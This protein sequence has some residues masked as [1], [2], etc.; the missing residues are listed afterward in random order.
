M[1]DWFI[2]IFRIIKN[3]TNS[4]QYDRPSVPNVEELITRNRK[5]IRQKDSIFKLGRFFEYVLRPLSVASNTHTRVYLCIKDFQ[6]LYSVM[7]KKEEWSVRCNYLS[8]PL[9]REWFSFS[10]YLSPRFFLLYSRWFIESDDRTRLRRASVYLA[11]LN[12]VYVLVVAIARF[13]RLST[14]WNCRTYVP[15]RLYIVYCASAITLPFE[16]LYLNIYWGKSIFDMF[17]V[18]TIRSE[19]FIFEVLQGKLSGGKTTRYFRHYLFPQSKIRFRFICTFQLSFLWVFTNFPVALPKF[20]NFAVLFFP[21][22]A[23]FLQFYFCLRL[24]L[25]EWDVN[26]LERHTRFVFFFMRKYLQSGG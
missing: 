5:R 14:N 19:N 26:R 20:E 18:Y 24:F 10:L 3:R 1:R 6:L 21:C 4:I 22:T 7:I 13:E 16:Y 23:P 17:P 8:P 15:I 9:L 25:I 2:G 11:L 12:A